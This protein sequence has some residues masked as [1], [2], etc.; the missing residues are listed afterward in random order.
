[1]KQVYIAIFALTV[2]SVACQL[3]Q[4]T[5]TITPLATNLGT[6]V[7]QIT[8]DNTTM[9]Y[10][11]IGGLTADELREEMNQF[12]PVDP[13]EGLRYDS[14]TDWYISWTWPGYGEVECDLS[15]AHVSYDIKVTVP[16]W[17]PSPKTNPAL[18]DH[19]NRYMNNLAIH[20]QA[21]VDA[22]IN[23]YLQVKDAIQGATCATAEPA[24][25]EILDKLKQFQIEYDRQTKHG[26]TQ[27]A[28]FP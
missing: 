14:L 5:A 3:S 28:V 8:L 1:M 21:H 12:G 13:N 10:Y 20:E 4:L 27:G 26:E 11:E 18:I 2:S 25:Q 19:W 23:H 9:I 6:E 22:I 15:Q 24:A 7:V 16:R 17:H